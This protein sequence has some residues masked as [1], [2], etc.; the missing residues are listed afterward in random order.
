MTEFMS[1]SHIDP[2]L[3][4][5][6][7]R[8][9]SAT[10]Q[11]RL[12][13]HLE[14]CSDCLARARSVQQED[15]Q[16][17]DVVRDL[18]DS[19][20][21]LLVGRLEADQLVS[22]SKARSLPGR[23]PWFLRAR[24]ALTL[25]AGLAFLIAGGWWVQQL[26][27]PG[28]DE[29][30]DTDELAL[31]D[32]E[33]P[34]EGAAGEVDRDL[35]VALASFQWRTA[36]EAPR[37]LFEDGRVVSLESGVGSA[38]LFDEGGEQARAPQLGARQLGSTELGPRLSLGDEV[39]VGLLAA[40]RLEVAERGSPLKVSFGDGSEVTLLPGT[41]FTVAK[42]AG[43]RRI[44]VE[45]GRG[46]FSVNRKSGEGMRVTTPLAS[47]EVV[48]TEFEVYHDPR[49]RS[50]LTADRADGRSK[51]APVVGKSRVWVTSGR[52]LASRRGSVLPGVPV[53]GGFD[54][55]VFPNR[56]VLNPD[57]ARRRS[58]SA[59]SKRSRTAPPSE[60]EAAPEAQKRPTGLDLPHSFPHDKRGSKQGSP[61]HEKG[62][63]R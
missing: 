63:K 16:I 9:L 2:W 57:L 13:A 22:S 47:I 8:E 14:S 33:A 61:L 34:G 50:E 45:A 7:D 11:R 19:M 1:C 17:A 24:R 37:V 6:V 18:S 46:L 39:T 42:Q 15:L 10:E 36:G 21:N 40:S 12:E 56:L 26:M 28:T 49:F 35:E 5:S 44:H 48:G 31:H 58:P 25:A 27:G 30:G 60:T 20:E 51:R 62:Q 41:V 23:G 3:S 59:E 29:V 52:V 4:L 38:Q 32:R 54:V 43:E 53:T 55:A